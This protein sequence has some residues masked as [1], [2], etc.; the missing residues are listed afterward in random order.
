MSK[1]VFAIGKRAVCVNKPTLFTISA[2][3]TSPNGNNDSDLSVGA[4]IYA[5]C[6]SKVDSNV[7][8]YVILYY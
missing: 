6:L 1:S 3:Y 7:Y 2:L 8:I 5:V 4:V